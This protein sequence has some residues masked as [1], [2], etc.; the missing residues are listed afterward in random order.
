MG[1]YFLFNLNRLD[2]LTAILIQLQSKR[3][4]KAQEIADRFEISLRTVYRDI[5]TLELAG[6]P[7]LSEAGIGYSLMKDYRLPPVQ[8]TT[9]EALAFFTAEK[10][11]SKL[12][13]PKSRKSFESGLF[14]VKAVLGN[15]EKELLEEANAYVAIVENRILPEQTTVDFPEILN[16]IIQKKVIK[17]KYFSH[18]NFEEKE[19]FIEPVGIFSQ[20]GNWYLIAWCRLRADYRNFRFDR[21]VDFEVKNER[22][23]QKHPELSSFLVNTAKEK[24]LT[25]VVIRLDKS[26]YRY[27]GNQ[28]FYMGFVSQTDLGEQIEMSFLSASLEGFSHWFLMI[29]SEADVLEPENLKAMVLKKMD[30]IKNRLNG[31]ADNK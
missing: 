31:K 9:D 28:H 21:I 25:K 8:F 2:R 4:V 11:F 10:I 6:V 20:S 26:A 3:I 17:L 1:Y 7:I 12:S 22:F 27:L 18:T 30:N 14:K 23:T 24:A 19:R 16:C 5:R 15:Y 29:G 13:D